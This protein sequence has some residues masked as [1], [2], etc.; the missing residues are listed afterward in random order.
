MRKICRIAMLDYCCLNFEL[1][2]ACKHAPRG[3]RVRCKYATRR[4]RPA[5]VPV[6]A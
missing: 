3:E 4:G 1:P 5:I 6:L 2:K